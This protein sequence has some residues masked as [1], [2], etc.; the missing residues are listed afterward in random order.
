LV[1]SNLSYEFQIDSIDH[2]E[3]C[4]KEKLEKLSNTNSALGL[5]S[6]SIFAMLNYEKPDINSIK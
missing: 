2:L 3:N 1:Y 5:L 6:A 4:P